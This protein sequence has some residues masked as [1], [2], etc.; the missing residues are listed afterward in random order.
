MAAAVSAV[1]ST[2]DKLGMIQKLEQV[3]S[4]AQ[5]RADQLKSELALDEAIYPQELTQ[6]MGDL[7]KKAEVVG[8]KQLKEIIG[9]EGFWGFH[10]ECPEKMPASLV[11][12]VDSY[13]LPG[14]LVRCASVGQK[15]KEA[16]AEII[17]ISQRYS[18]IKG[19]CWVV[20]R[21][22]HILYKTP[23]TVTAEFIG[24]KEFQRFADL[25]GGKQIV[26][27]DGIAWKKI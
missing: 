22:S 8:K 18:N 1:L 9:S 25:A 26:D 2:A 10:G 17:S 13:G 4:E 23:T 15:Y 19:S 12:A 24:A 14:F 6:A 20:R 3:A 16:Y 5:L 7:V 11:K 21:G 27:A